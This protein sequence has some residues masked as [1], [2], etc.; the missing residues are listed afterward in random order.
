MQI[1]TLVKNQF[2]LIYHN[3]VVLQELFPNVKFDYRDNTLV[4]LPKK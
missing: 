2:I 3:I 4:F 1:Y